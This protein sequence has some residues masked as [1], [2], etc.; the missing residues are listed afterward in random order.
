MLSDGV[1]LVA[2]VTGFTKFGGKVEKK[3]KAAANAARSVEER[4][5][6]RACVQAAA[7]LRG[8]PGIVLSISGQV[9]VIFH[10][11]GRD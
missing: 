5:L 6:S 7:R 1:K 4:R 11:F 9:G 2:E 8:R 3:R 10:I